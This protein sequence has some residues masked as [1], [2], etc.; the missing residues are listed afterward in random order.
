MKA[1]TALMLVLCCDWAMAGGPVKCFCWD[2]RVVYSDNRTC[3]DETDHNNKCHAG[4]SASSNG[5]TSSIV[6]SQT[7]KAFNF[8]IDSDKYVDGG[9]VTSKPSVPIT[10]QR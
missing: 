8:T 5:G 9:I 3:F 1:L 4:T 6:D 10:R 2:G 7:V